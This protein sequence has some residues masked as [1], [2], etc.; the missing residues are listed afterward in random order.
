[1]HRPSTHHNV[2]YSSVCVFVSADSEARF[3]LNPRNVTLL[4]GIPYSMDCVA[5]HVSPSYFYLISM[6]PFAGSFF[7]PSDKGTPVRTIE[8]V[9]LQENNGNILVCYA[10]GGILESLTPSQPGHL[11]VHSEYSQCVS[12][13]SSSHSSHTFVR[14]HIYPHPS[15][16]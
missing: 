12:V 16:K 6:R 7:Y 8:S 3:L 4:E 13:T 15:S 1:M 5:L 14:I 9:S 11:T 10:A 2:H